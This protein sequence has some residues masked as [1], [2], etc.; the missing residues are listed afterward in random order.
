MATVLEPGGNKARRAM[1]IHGADG[2]RQVSR[3]GLGWS[4]G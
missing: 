4:A 1:G 3:T 2:E